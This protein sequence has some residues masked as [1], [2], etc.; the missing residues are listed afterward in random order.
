[1]RVLLLGNDTPACESVRAFLVAAGEDV[2]LWT[3]QVGGDL[4]GEFLPDIALSYS[5]RWILR[6]EVFT[7]PRLGT[8]NA[9]VSYLPW[10]RGA[11]PNFWSHAE[12]TPKGV[13]LHRIDKGI[14]TG[15]LIAREPVCFGEDDTLRTSY[16][17]LHARMLALLETWWPVIRAGQAPAMP[18][19]PVGT[20]HLQKD[21]EPF[22]HVLARRGWDTP[23]R[24]VA[25]LA[26]V[27]ETIHGDRR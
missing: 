24:E 23:V 1:M 12:G 3:V 8:V 22:R 15:A 13:S 17:K 4:L 5:F 7:F 25:A 10:N 9:H 16:E 20:F 27:H 21:L 11:D 26:L 6:E 2:R 19:E 14:D 18:P